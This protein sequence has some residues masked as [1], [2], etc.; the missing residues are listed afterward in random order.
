MAQGDLNKLIQQ[1]KQLLVVDPQ[2]YKSFKER[3]NTLESI[4]EEAAGP[5]PESPL[6]KNKDI[7]ESAAMLARLN[8]VSKWLGPSK[9]TT[10]TVTP[11]KG[12]L[13]DAKFFKEKTR[14]ALQSFLQDTDWARQRGS[15]SPVQAIFKDLSKAVRDSGGTSTIKQTPS[16]RSGKSAATIRRGELANRIKDEKDAANFDT[17]LISLINAKLPPAVRA[18]M[19]KDGALNNRTGRLSESVRLAGVERT[20]QGYPRLLYT[21][22][23]SPYD[24]FDPVLGALPWAT[25]GRD[26]KILIDKSIRDIARDMAIGRFYTRRA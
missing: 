2:W 25:P 15:D 9:I 18:N 16:R 21:Y 23:R 10:L 20:P 17:S 11:E 3:P 4:Q 26:P 22:Q 13:I 12:T 6:L 14:K 19:G 5:R 24:V 1:A 8:L 7:Y